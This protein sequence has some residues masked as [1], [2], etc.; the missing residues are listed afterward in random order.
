M[1]MYSRFIRHHGHIAF[2]TGN[3]T[4]LA[5]L[6]RR[7]LM[8]IDEKNVRCVAF[9]REGHAADVLNI[10]RP[11]GLISVPGLLHLRAGEPPVRVRFGTTHLNQPVEQALG[12]GRHK[13]VEEVFAHCVNDDELFI[14]GCD[15]NATPPGTTLGSDCQTY[16][17]MTARLSDA[18][19]VAN[20]SDPT[21]DGLTWDLQENKMWTS[22]WSRIFYGSGVFRWRCDYIFWRKP[23]HGDR[24]PRKHGLES[25][26]SDRLQRSSELTF[27]VRS[28]DVVFAGPDAVSDHFG[29]HAVFELCAATGGTSIQNTYSRCPKP[30]SSN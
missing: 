12:D 11:R 16:S 28:C 3:R 30:R 1:V 21:R 26:T 8:D 25:E 17:D 9:S 24:A 4:G 2:L 22:N 5:M 14:L 13:Q 20:P 18:W 27:A 7:S 23:A 6:V 10:L 29:V 19:T 15:L